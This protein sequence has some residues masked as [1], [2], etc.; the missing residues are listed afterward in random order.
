MVE[1]VSESSSSGM[2]SE[3]DFHSFTATFLFIISDNADGYRL[4]FEFVCV[5][6][7]IRYVYEQA[8][9]TC[10]NLEL[11]RFPAGLSGTGVIFQ[12]LHI[13]MFLLHLRDLRIR[14]EYLCL[15]DPFALLVGKFP[16]S[17]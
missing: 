5:G 12:I 14:V 3:H 1:I 10:W 15:I 11:R 9:V 16:R 8:V 4:C 13:D 7:G 2:S 17:S 6:L